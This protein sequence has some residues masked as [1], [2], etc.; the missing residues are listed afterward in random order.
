[1]RSA[2]HNSDVDSLHFWVKHYFV[3]FYCPKCKQ[4]TLINVNELNTTVIKEPDAKPI[5][6]EIFSQLS[7]L[8]FWIFR[9]K[10]SKHK[11]VAI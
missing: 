5:I 8:S 11:T 4:T 9:N 2:R 6:D 10:H 3:P 1:M 7:A